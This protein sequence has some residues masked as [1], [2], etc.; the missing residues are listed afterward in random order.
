M[1]HFLLLLY[2]NRQ[3]ERKDTEGL[4]LAWSSSEWARVETAK[5]SKIIQILIVVDQQCLH[6]VHSWKLKA[7]KA[8]LLSGRA[9]PGSVQSQQSATRVTFSNCSGLISWKENLSKYRKCDCL[10]LARMKCRFWRWSMTSRWLFTSNF[11]V[12]SQHLEIQKY[13]R[14]HFVLSLF[15]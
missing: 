9:W 12:E 10:A 4:K 14:P 1:R 2:Q 7:A 5:L 3:S 13:R 15:H 11:H 8:C 6:H